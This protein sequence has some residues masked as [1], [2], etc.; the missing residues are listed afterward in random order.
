MESTASSNRPFLE[1]KEE[2]G[3]LKAS[4]V[5]FEM[6]GEDHS[7][8]IADS[9]AALIARIKSG[10]IRLCIVDVMDAP[11]FSK[12]AAELCITTPRYVCD[13][14]EKEIIFVVRHITQGTRR[15]MHEAAPE[16]F[17]KPY[18]ANKPG[19]CL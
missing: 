6:P 4:V 10:E 5:F 18:K 9:S 7:N 13:A 11:H 14:Q 15:H 17:P 19:C 8:S 16:Y 12:E 3:V 2:N 1:L